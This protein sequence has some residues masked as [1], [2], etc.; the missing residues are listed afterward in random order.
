MVKA[1]P[2]ACAARYS[3]RPTISCAWRIVPEIED[4]VEVEP[5]LRS[6]LEQL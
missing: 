5:E 2:D 4:R 6:R 1:Y 3:S